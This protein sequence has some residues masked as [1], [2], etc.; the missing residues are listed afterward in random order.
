MAEKLS[1][2]KVGKPRIVRL[3]RQAYCALTADR[4]IFITAILRG[5][6]LPNAMRYCWRTILSN[7]HVVCRDSADKN[8]GPF[9]VPRGRELAVVRQ[10][11]S[12][13]LRHVA[14]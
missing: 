9:F 10:R 13:T 6:D 14:A 8:V 3:R 1:L 2:Q 4:D 5:R 12:N 11:E 7:R